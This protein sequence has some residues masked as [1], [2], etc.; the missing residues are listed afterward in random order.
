MNKPR[1]LII[2]DEPGIRTSLAGILELKG[3][4]VNTAKNGSEGLITLEEGHFNLALLDLDLPDTTGLDLLRQIKEK[5]PDMEAIILTGNATFDSAVE[6]TNLGVFSYLVKPYDIDQLLLLIRRAIEKQQ[7]AAEL[8]ASQLQM[9]QSEKMASI[10]QLAAGVAHEINNPMGFI[11][12]N[13]S[14]LAKYTERMIDFLQAQSE[15]LKSQF[16]SDKLAELEEKRKQIKLDYIVSDI[17]QLISE[18]LEGAKRVKNIVQDLKTFSRRDEKEWKFADI[19]NCLESTLNVVWNEVKYKAELIKSYG[20]LPPLKCNPGQLNQVFMNLLVNAA[21]AMETRGT[22][23]LK[24]WHDQG[25]I[26]VLISDTGCGIP[27]EAKDRIFEPFFTTKEVGK[28]TGLG[29]SI[30]YDI[31]KKHDGRIAVESK[32]GH[33]S[34]FTVILPCNDEQVER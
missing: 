6:A 34:T 10:G 13:L 9:F 1:I 14:T 5:Y 12:S 33:G 20:D 22:I 32:P 15:L 8:Q 28:G 17:P 18:S 26:H 19:N 11:L 23:T 3:Y 4:E 31:V 30:S 25:C 2:D 7:S 16:E 29:L 21:Q 27:D 24:S